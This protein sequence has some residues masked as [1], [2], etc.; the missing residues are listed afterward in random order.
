M[1]ADG[2]NTE[3]GTEVDGYERGLPGLHEVNEALQRRKRLL[4]CTALV[5]L[6]LGC[7]MHFLIP[8]KY[9]ASATLFLVHPSGSNE[10]QA[11]AGEASILRSRAVATAA[12]QDLN[13]RVSP[14]DFISRYRPVIVSDQILS[15]VL[16]EKSQAEAI[17]EDQAVAH[18]F[19]DVRDSLLVDETEGMLAGL[20]EQSE[21]LKG[22][23]SHLTQSI[24]ALAS[25]RTGSQAATEVDL[26]NQRGLDESQLSQ[27]QQQIG[28]SRLELAAVTGGSRILDPADGK[29]TSTI[30]LL[31]LNGISGLVAGL[32]GG[33]LFILIDAFV[34]DR[35]RRR[36][37]IA[38]ALGAPV[39]V[40]VPRR[41]MRWLLPKY[42]SRRRVR[43]PDKAT[44]SCISS[45]RWCLDSAQGRS[46][47][48]VA[49]GDVE[50]AAV[51]VAGLA[52]VLVN[53]GR[54]VSVENLA[55]EYP[56]DQLIPR[57]LLTT[58]A[59]DSP[60]QATAGE[61]PRGDSR[62]VLA[63]LKP[64]NGTVHISS[65][66]RDTVVVVTAGKAHLAEL[67]AIRQ[68]LR[69]AGMELRSILL[70][71]SDRHDKSF[72]IPGARLTTVGSI[73]RHSS[74]ARLA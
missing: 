26:V 1:T 27:L 5:G 7:S 62:L 29:P 36:D 63:T 33:A 9:S 46:L 59:E 69:F 28:Q 48:V 24:D 56:L 6:L 23:I 67:T 39:D 35:A 10:Q 61:G 41:R 20:S 66:A 12:L 72:G 15:V 47:C 71:G 4:L 37:E 43:R 74:P 68:V 49:V 57:E 17:R 19:L 30:K 52:A 51:A 44:Q 54:R 70:V 3:A 65:L 14:L 45:L 22:E 53:D 38:D 11:I 13:L 73:D 55:T 18:A 64:G 34:S 2:Y 50:P 16:T 58:M 42:R 8:R 60:A 40:D 21:A 25:G 31:A 32:G